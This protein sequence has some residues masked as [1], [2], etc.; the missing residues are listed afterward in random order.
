MLGVGAVLADD[1][2]SYKLINKLVLAVLIA[3]L[4]LEGQ[5]G[6][7]A[8]CYCYNF[9]HIFYFFDFKKDKIC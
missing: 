4:I 7:F 5:K 3:G 9:N 1:I 8:V 6:E 2:A